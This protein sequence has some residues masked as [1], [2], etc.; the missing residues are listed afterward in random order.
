MGLGTNLGNRH[1]NLVT[2]RQYLSDRAGKIMA[3][4]GIYESAPWGYES[5]NFFY[6]QCLELETKH[7]PHILLE[8][9]QEIEQL[10]GRVKVSAGYA[11]RIIDLDLLFYD[12]L[13]IQSGGLKIPHP[14]MEERAFV[15]VPLADIS[16]DKV[17]PGTGLTVEQL[18]DRCAEK[19]SV[20]PV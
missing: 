16:P 9:M 5:G 4:S 11:D 12:D 1:E 13:V 8:I 15:L 3:V 6:N 17:H 19:D 18:L 20:G 7:P 14:R 10:M 2:A